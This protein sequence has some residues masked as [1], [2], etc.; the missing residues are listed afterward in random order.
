[1]PNIFIARHG[2]TNWNVAG[3]YQGR[4]DTE[5]SQ[6]GMAQSQAL[7]EAMS[8]AQVQRIISSPLQRCITT[9]QPTAQRTGVTIEQE[10]LLI[11][12]AHGDWEGRY[13]DELESNDPLRYHQWRKQPEI[14]S[15]AGGESVAEVLERWITFVKTF[16]ATRDA[17]IVTHDAVIRVALIERLRRPLARFW[18]GKVLNGAFV[19]FAVDASG[20]TLMDECV[21]THLEGIIADPSGQAL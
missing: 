14:V 11:E 17:L 12:I 19:W 13:R 9:A 10:P 3:R 1:M 8:I 6:R 5:L 20:W 2:E 7:G 15:F 18:D 16:D 4:R 21:S